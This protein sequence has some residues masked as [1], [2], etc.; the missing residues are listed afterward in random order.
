MVEWESEI[1][2]TGEVFY[3]ESTEESLLENPTISENDI[4]SPQ[5]ELTRRR[6]T[7]AG[8]L[9]RLIRRKESKRWSTKNKRIINSA[10][11]NNATAQEKGDG[12]K[13]V[14]FQDFQVLIEA[15][16]AL[17]T[18]NYNIFWKHLKVNDFKTRELKVK[19]SCNLINLT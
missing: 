17:T 19:F 3:I 8:K 6:S 1:E 7:R 12:T 14:K 15:I 18:I 5:P 10:A 16:N 2:P 4:E 9:F 13:E 11:T